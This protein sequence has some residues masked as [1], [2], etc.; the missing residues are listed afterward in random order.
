MPSNLKQPGFRAKLKIHVILT[1]MD[2]GICKPRESKKGDSSSGIHEKSQTVIFPWSVSQLCP[3]PQSDFVIYWTVGSAALFIS[4]LCSGGKSRP[5]MEVILLASVISS[6][7]G[8]P[9]LATGLAGP[10]CSLLLAKLLNRLINISKSK[11][12]DCCYVGLLYTVWQM[13]ISFKW[14]AVGATGLLYVRSFVLCSSFSYFD[15]VLLWLI[16]VDIYFQEGYVYI[17]E[18]Q[19]RYRRKRCRNYVLTGAFA[20]RW[21]ICS[22]L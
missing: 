20:S 13:D 15:Q 18:I 9:C 19:P 22:P 10:C 3:L 11:I 6:R 17:S 16:F 14:F 8:A 12:S 4:S 21:Q 5:Q 1:W 2:F 7:S